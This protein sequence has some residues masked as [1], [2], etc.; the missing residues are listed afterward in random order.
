MN[1]TFS[2][3]KASKKQARARIITDGPAGSGK[4]TTSILLGMG[5]LEGTNKRV[6]LGDTEYHSAA[7]TAGE[8]YGPIIIDF[9]HEILEPPYHPEKAI[10][11]MKYAADQ[12]YGAVVIDSFT[13]FWK[14]AGGFLSL[15][16]EWVKSRI[17]RGKKGDSHG[18]WKELGPLYDTLV[19]SIQNSP[20]HVLAT[21]RAKMG[22]ERIEENGRTKIQKIGLQ[23]E[24][25]DGFEYEFDMEA[26]MD[27][28]NNMAIGKTRYRPLKGKVF[29][30]PGIDLARLIRKCLEDGE[31]DEKPREIVVVQKAPPAPET[32]KP[33]P[34]ESNEQR[35]AKAVEAIKKITDQSGIDAIAKTLANS[36]EWLRKNPE[37]ENEF[38]MAQ[39]RASTNGR[40]EAQP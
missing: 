15:I 2:P 26:S 8:Q 29:K 14:G 33:Q 23:T 13:H 37:V 30:E 19:Q 3:K 39:L 10:A 5:L 25:R 36:P 12:G 21:A 38:L 18:A 11:F 17:A 7:K 34:A 31:V 4:T 1:F 22:T 27:M 35:I 40:A 6:L 32:P 28:D 9:D 20:I 24:M 16:D